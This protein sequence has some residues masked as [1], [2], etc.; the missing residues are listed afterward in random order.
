MRSL[1]VGMAL[2]AL[3]TSGC[4]GRK[5]ECDE[6]TV[7]MVDGTTHVFGQYPGIRADVSYRLTGA[8]MVVEEP[9][10]YRGRARP[11]GA[12]ET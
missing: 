12:N 3:G 4:S 2:L 10:F 1:V 5:V 7:T 6:L 11:F 9:Y 8:T